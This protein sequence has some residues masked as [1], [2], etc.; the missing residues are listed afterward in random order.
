MDD[1]QPSPK[2][3]LGL[4]MLFT[5][6]MVVGGLF[7]SLLKIWSGPQGNLGGSHRTVKLRQ[8]VKLCSLPQ[9]AVQLKSA[10]GKASKQCLG[11]VDCT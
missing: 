8:G 11:N 5:G 3:P 6:Q 4:R 2:G 10:E 1:L 7:K 9:A